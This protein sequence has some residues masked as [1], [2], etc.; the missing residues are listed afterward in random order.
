MRHEDKRGS[1]ITMNANLGSF[2]GRGRRRGRPL[3]RG[4]IGM[5]M[6]GA[7]A[8]AGLAQPQIVHAE[9][10]AYEFIGSW[11]NA[12]ATVKSGSDT[13]SAVWRFDINDDSPAPSNDPV[14]NNIVT[15]TAQ[16]ATFSG[17][18]EVCLTAGVTPASSLSADRRTLVC[19]IGTR[20]QGT[21]QVSF[22]GLIPVGNSG[23][24]VT[25][26]GEFR[27]KTV[28]LPK[29][30][31]ANPFVMDAKFDG[32]STIAAAND[33]Q[34]VSFG[35]SVSH[36][37]GSLPGPSTVSYDLT[38]AG[39]NG[40]TL[41]LDGDGCAPISSS[42]AGFPYSDTAHGQDQTAPFPTCTLTSVG[43]G[44]FRLTL[45][46]LNYSSPAPTRDSRGAA[47]P[48]GM[49][50]IAAGRI[51]LKFTYL[52]PGTLTLNATTPTYVA[53]GNPSVT[54]TDAASNNTNSLAYTRGVW[55]HGFQSTGALSQG[56]VWTDTYRTFA[57]TSVY[58]GTGV[59]ATVGNANCVLLDTKYVTFES[60]KV[61]PDLTAAPHS[62]AAIWYYTGTAGG[63]LNPASASYDPNAW[64]G[65]ETNTPAADGW[66]TTLPADLSTV[67]AAMS[68]HTQALINQGTGTDGLLN[69]YVSQRIKSNAATGQDIWSWG[70]FKHNGT[71]FTP[72]RSL[73]PSTRPPS[74]TLTP[75]ARYPYA[76]GGR[77]VLRIIGS[78]PVVQK[79]VA[80]KE[81]GPGTTV[82]YTLRYGLTADASGDAPAQVVLVDTLPVGMAYVVGSSTPV[83]AISGTPATGQT[84]TWTI[85]NVPVNKTP[86]DVINFKAS[87]PNSAA[88]GTT[89]TNNV[90]AS[91]QGLNS[92]ASAQFSVPKAGYT[93]LTK[94]A[95]A[96][97]VPSTN[98]AA[99]DGWTIRMTSVDPVSSAATDT[100]DILPYLGDGRGTSFS[101]TY[102]LKQAVQTVAG[103][104]VYYTTAAH[105]SLNEDPKDA[106]NG[107]FATTTG[108]TVGW[109]TTYNENATAV[110]VIGPA[111]AY[112]NT[113]D[114][115]IQVVTSGS[116]G[117]D[118]FVN[119]AVGRASDTQ[120]RMRTSAQFEIEA[121]PA[122]VLKKYMRDSSGNWH[123][124]QDA[125]D[126]PTY[127]VGDSV[128]Y[129]LVVENTGNMDLENL[130]LT[131]TKVDLGQ[132]FQD[133]KLTTD[134]SLEGNAADGV[135]IK[136][137]TPNQK[138]TIEYD[139]VIAEDAVEGNTLLNT[140]CVNPEEGS[141]TDLEPSC[142][143]A[144][145]KVLASLA[146]EKISAYSATTFLEGSEWELVQVTGDG[147]GPVAGASAVPVADCVAGQA[148]DCTGRDVD[149]QTG[150]FKVMSLEN[151]WYR[152]TETKSPVGYKLDTTPRYVQV[153]G[154]YKLG[155][156]IVNELTDVPTIPLTGGVGSFGFWAVGGLGG[157]LVAAG[158]LWQRRRT[159]MI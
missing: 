90:K 70:S 136:L 103:A 25:V 73:D 54:S 124:A 93:T 150:R 138:A 67:K 158:L 134:V 39:S 120:L 61:A 40:E 95:T 88:P 43:A 71:W 31:I 143:P 52:S 114:F 21:A 15:F 110:R 99:E 49:D 8:L 55:T 78:A 58:S 102:K 156:G 118:T 98:G 18:P 64:T 20:N 75:G 53:A 51:S 157:L 13:L 14:D 86:L 115:T 144:G 27:G 108:N 92:T 7:L 10:V 151:G 60:A 104:T 37:T 106:S 41:S 12:P 2:L 9:T 50:V 69:L 109:S 16:N 23:D 148:A 81:A 28:E 33:Q 29:I 139:L 121:M 133:G 140:A 56:T 11:E 45:S 82:D 62:G 68:F 80:Q 105:A 5:T 46:N 152:L 89:Y 24:L 59:Q 72:N 94:T 154:V 135:W 130:P 149:P 107:G 147:G 127:N 131:D 146:W 79:E 96:P 155:E 126:F 113:Q 101:G 47:L 44:K 153:S 6:V 83:P 19:N 141:G 65:C 17:I 38:L 122:V 119:T 22:T 34:L 132:F 63:L 97:L 76:A 84:L 100:V 111:L 112:G 145:I 85:A 35:W 123:D 57:G 3:G 117:G 74:G 30:P 137:L 91:S 36:S 4:L 66:T 128:R 48:L 26:T 159:L 87:V 42:Y 1:Q 142:D 77:D 129:R 32:G 116:K 125:T